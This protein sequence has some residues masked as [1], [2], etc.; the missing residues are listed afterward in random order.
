MVKLKWIP[1]AATLLLPLSA[2][3]WK[4][5]THVYLA[6]QAL[7]DALDD[8]NV[9]IYRVNYDTGA[10]LEKIGDYPVDPE[11]LAAIRANRRQYRA[12][13]LG[14]D[15]F[16]DIA[17]GQSAIH[18]GDDPRVGGL[19]GDEP[20]EGSDAWLRHL[21]QRSRGQSPET[22]AWTAGFMTHAAGD[23]FAHTFVNAYAGGEFEMGDNALRHL[24]LEG[25]LGKRCVSVSD[26]DVSLDGAS[27]FI[28]DTLCR[29]PAGSELARLLVGK[30]AEQSPIK[31][32]GDLRVTLT[33][34]LDAYDKLSRSKKL[35]YDVSHPGRIPYLK[36]W[37]KD[38]DDGLRA[39]PEFSQKLAVQLMFNPTGLNKAKAKSEVNDFANKHLLSMLGLPDAVGVAKQVV[40]AIGLALLTQAQRDE[41][42]AIEKD[43]LNNLCVK[44]FGFTLDYLADRLEN[45]EN[46]IDEVIGPGSKGVERAQRTTLAAL[47]HDV[48]KLKDDAYT[49]PN[50][51]WDWHTFPPAYNTVTLTKLSFLSAETVNR[52]LDD[53]GKDR[54]GVWPRLSAGSNVLLDYQNSLDNDN[55]WHLNQGELIFVRTNDYKSLFMRQIGERP[56]VH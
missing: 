13:V 37:V 2:H 26:F 56:E 44:A 29:M 40:E 53:L 19:K 45:P 31:F 49:D 14:P 28:T 16:P 6:E 39:W 52:L 22:R 5:T 1:L 15:A 30:G 12:G 43:F 36:A 17:T 47:N 46:Y 33:T 55:Q 48:L 8:G 10:I 24:V 9:S 18:P 3:A 4:P 11:L 38:I 7:A 50:E 42:K 23:L 35:S 25:Y 27:E 41:I 54:A 32:F 21:W 34:E 51:R 20:G